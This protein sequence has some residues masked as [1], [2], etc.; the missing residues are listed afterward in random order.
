MKYYA[1]FYYF[2]VDY[3]QRRTKFREE[4]LKLARELNNR[5]ELIIAGAF[6]D[7]SDKALLIFCVK[8]KSVI[9]EFIRKDPYYKNGLVTS[10]EIREWTVVIGNK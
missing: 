2:V 10:Y 9:E 1:L 7:P 5:G 4:H 3:L 8:D 6:N